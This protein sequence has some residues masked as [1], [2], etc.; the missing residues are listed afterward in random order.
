MGD[1]NE[2][3][4]VNERK[5]ARRSIT[6][7]PSGEGV[8][9]IRADEA[10][11]ALDAGAAAGRRPDDQ[12]RFGDVPPA[13]SGPRSP[14]R[15]PLPA[16]VDP[17]G[18]VPLPPL[19]TPPGSEDLDLDDD[20]DFDDDLDLGDDLEVG[21]DLDLGPDLDLDEE[22]DPEEDQEIDSEFELAA[23]SRTATARTAT[24][25]GRP[26]AGVAPAAAIG[27]AWEIGDRTAELRFPRTRPGRVPAGRDPIPMAQTSR[28]RPPAEPGPHPP[29]NTAS[30]P[31]EGPRSR[32][33]LPPRKGSP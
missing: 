22:L 19:A 17:A 20:P 25:G 27:S 6:A 28:L 2:E 3:D 10:Q 1:G 23:A 26:A 15:F 4:A 32:R 24:W 12:L 8:R 11:A 29:G 18:A 7:A 13:P 16:S 5:A 21:E 33:S 14:H 30:P 9:I 31:T